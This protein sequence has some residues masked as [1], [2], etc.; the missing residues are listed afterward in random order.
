MSLPRFTGSQEKNTALLI[1]TNN[2]ADIVSPMD[3]SNII[4]E[5]L[6][7][8]LQLICFSG[9]LLEYDFKQHVASDIGIDQKFLPNRNSLSQ[10]YIQQICDWTDIQKMK[11][12]EDKSKVMIITFS[13]NQ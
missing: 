6:F 7:Y 8:H 12:N 9:L 4:N 11:L 1:Q 2:N 13:K 10:G 3:K 5:S